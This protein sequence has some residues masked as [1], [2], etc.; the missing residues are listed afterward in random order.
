MRAGNLLAVIVSLSISLPLGEGLLRLFVN[1]IDLLVPDVLPDAERSL[2]IRPYSAGHDARGYRNAFVPAR[3]DIVAVGDSQT[4]CVSTSAESSWPRVLGRRLGRVVYNMA[5][6][7]YNPVDYWSLVDEEVFAFSPSAIVVALYYGNDLREAFRS[8]Y[9]KDH[10]R[11]LRRPE[12]SRPEILRTEAQAAGAPVVPLRFMGGIRRWFSMHSVFYRVVTG[13]IRR[14]LPPGWATEPGLVG[15]AVVFTDGEHGISTLLT[16]THRLGVIDLGDPKVEEGLRIT[17]DMFHRMHARASAQ[18]VP[19]L[20]V[21]I[22]TKESVLWPYAGPHTELSG[23]QELAALI[24]A[25][26]RVDTRVRDAFARDALPYVSL[27]GPLQEAAGREEVYPFTDGHPNAQGCEVIASAI[28]VRLAEMG[29]GP[30]A[31]MSAPEAAR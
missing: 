22:P 10:W 16:P 7:G 3:A 17:L 18:G 6:P 14:L 4:Y 20:A 5:V 23:S 29:I 15:K 21:L 30:E 1:P 31:T 19:M 9:G 27:L 28:Q 25:E 11:A 8:V 2:R 26:Q 24:V 13:Q 12:F